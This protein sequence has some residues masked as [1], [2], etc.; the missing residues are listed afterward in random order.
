MSKGDGKRKPRAA[1]QSG[2]KLR[3]QS[4]VPTDQYQ[5]I[6]DAE[7]VDVVEELA[8]GV[9]ALRLLVLEATAHLPAA[10]TSIAEAGH[11]V[12]RAASGTPG[13]NKILPTLADTAG[14]LDAVL[15]ALPGGEPLIEAVLALG[16][17]RPVI[18]AAS[19]T[20]GTEAVRRAASLGADLTTVRPHDLERLAPVLL[21][22]ARL[23]EQRRSRAS[24]LGGVLDDLGRADSLGDI[25]DYA[26]LDEG[27]EPE[28]GVLWPLARFRD[29]VDHELARAARFA[30]P[31]SLAIFELSVAP[32]PPPAFV[33]GIL[34]AR[35]GNALVHAVRDIDVAT[36]LEQDRF[37]VLLPY[38]DRLAAADVARKILAAVAAADPVVAAGRSLAPR[39]IG[40]IAGIR[41][42]ETVTA[43]ELMRD[44]TQLLEQTAV[45]G[46]SLAVES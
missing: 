36:E 24:S 19:T 31:L 23:A 3:A 10:T 37:A 45:T 27:A 32:P 41:A 38:T 39:V 29:A 25:T 33:R 16:P 18:I 13:L 21:A 17:T 20:S 12:V 6:S 15:A 1:T 44:A 35:T 30:Y 42:G 8:P 14:Q 11:V 43:D 5:R 40:A 26:E 28:A 22:A 9:P 34:R 4:V 7:I 2:G 46:A